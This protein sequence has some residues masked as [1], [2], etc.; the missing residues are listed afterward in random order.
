MPQPAIVGR[1]MLGVRYFDI[2]FGI[3]DRVKK[4]FFR[5]ITHKLL[6]YSNFATKHIEQ[7]LGHLT[8]AICTKINDGGISRRF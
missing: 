3:V 4:T 5:A 6:M 8:S 7:I 1:T 2:A